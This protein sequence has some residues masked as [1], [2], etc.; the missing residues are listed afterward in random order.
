MRQDDY[1]DSLVGCNYFS[2]IDLRS[3]YW[4]IPLDVNSRDLTSFTVP[5]MGKFRFTRLPQGSSV[6]AAHFSHILTNILSDL[7]KLPIQTSQGKLACIVDYFDNITASS[8]D[9]KLHMVILR[10]L[11]ERLRQYNLSLNPNK[12]QFGYKKVEVLGFIVESGKVSMDP[13]RIKAIQKTG[14]EA[15]QYFHVRPPIGFI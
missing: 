15:G 8:E 6:S 14:P 4:N 1:I 7:R 11:F 5:D 13:N 10:K 9:F 3:G 12:S 2:T